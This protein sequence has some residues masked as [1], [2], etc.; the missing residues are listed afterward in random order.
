[1]KV[2][3]LFLVLVNNRKGAKAQRKEIVLI[4]AK[5]CVSAVKNIPYSKSNSVAVKIPLSL[6]FVIAF[7]LPLYL[8]STGTVRFL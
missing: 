4:Y 1:M 7:Q 3:R 6:F 8:M 2:C 5:H